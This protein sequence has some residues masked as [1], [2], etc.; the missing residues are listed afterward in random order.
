MYE[1]Y[2]H[3]SHGMLISILF[4]ARPQSRIPAE[5]HFTAHIFKKK[6][7]IAGFVHEPTINISPRKKYQQIEV[8]PIIQY[9]THILDKINFSKKLVMFIILSNGFFKLLLNCWDKNSSIVRTF[10]FT[11]LR[12]YD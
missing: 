1:K 10:H 12:K 5:L 7:I 2:S 6:M 3:G 11:K 9:F 4:D 8:T